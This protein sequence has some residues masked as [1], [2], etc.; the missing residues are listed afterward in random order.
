MRS[1]KEQMKKKAKKITEL[2]LLFDL[3]ELDSIVIVNPQVIETNQPILV[4]HPPSIPKSDLKLT[5]EK[6]NGATGIIETVFSY[7]T[8]G[9]K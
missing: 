7:F 9:L 5:Q 3:Q 4:T 2:N 6:P 1:Y 8:F